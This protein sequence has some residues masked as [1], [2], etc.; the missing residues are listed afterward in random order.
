MFQIT[1]RAKVPEE[2]HPR[3]VLVPA[4]EFSLKSLSFKSDGG[5]LAENPLSFLLL[6]FSKLFSSGSLS[7]QMMYFINS[8]DRVSLCDA[9]HRQMT[10]LTNVETDFHSSFG[11]TLA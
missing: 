2:C 6:L 9:R 8:L 1:V 3:I 10:E 11:W 4:N 7:H 5:Q